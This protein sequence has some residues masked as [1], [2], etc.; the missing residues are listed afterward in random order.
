MN[1]KSAGI[2][3]RYQ[4]STDRACTLFALADLLQSTSDT[5]RIAFSMIMKFD[6]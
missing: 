1:P 5:C 3:D 6:R 2:G 4:F